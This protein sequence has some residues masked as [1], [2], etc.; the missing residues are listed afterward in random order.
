TGEGL[1]LIE[2]APGIDLERDILA[3]MAFL[4]AISADLKVMDSRIFNK[5]TMGLKRHFGEVR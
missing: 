5:T 4:P 3:Q 1:E 2:I